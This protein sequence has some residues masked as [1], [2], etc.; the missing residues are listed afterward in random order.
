MTLDDPELGLHPHRLHVG[1]RLL[2]D[3]RGGGYRPRGRTCRR[4]AS[5]SSTTSGER[6]TGRN[7]EARMAEVLPDARWA[8]L[9]A[10]HPVFHSFFDINTLITE[11]YVRRGPVPAGSS[12][13]TI[14]RSGCWPWRNY[15]HDLGELW[16]FSDTGWVPRRTSSNEAYKYGVNYVIRLRDDTLESHGRTGAEAARVAKSL[17]PK[18]TGETW[19]PRTR[20][21]ELPRR[22]RAGRQDE[23]RARDRV[24]GG[25]AASSSSARTRSS[26]RCC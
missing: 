10:S 17:K 24:I 6:G 15:N 20:I 25:A 26:N 13:T 16:E 12:R 7:L 22:H 4:A 21:V 3:E 8:P 14:R 19:K 18:Q 23:R 11:G 2:D 9:D 5:S 1:A